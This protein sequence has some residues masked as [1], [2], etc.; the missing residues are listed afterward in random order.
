MDSLSQGRFAA[1]ICKKHLLVRET[2]EGHFCIIIPKIK[3]M[4]EWLEGI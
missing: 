2:N 4:G 3:K 1:N